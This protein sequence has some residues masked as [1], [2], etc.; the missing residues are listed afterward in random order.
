MGENDETRRYLRIGDLTLDTDTRELRRGDT[1]LDMTGLSYQLLL[2]LAE[3]APAVVSHEEIAER[4]WSGRVVSPET[5]TQRIKLLRQTLGDDARDPRYIALVRGHGYRLLA[6]VEPVD[7]AG[8]ADTPASEQRRVRRPWSVMLAL[9]VVAATVTAVAYIPQLRSTDQSPEPEAADRIPLEKSIAVLP[10]ED[11]SAGSELAYLGDGIADEVMHRL[12]QSDELHVVARTSSFALRDE[13]LD[14][15]AIAAR[16]GVHYVLQGS[17]RKSGDTLRVTAQLVDARRNAQLWSEAYERAADD[18]LGVQRDIAAALGELLEVELG[19]SDR[20]DPPPAAY[21]RLLQGRFYYNRRA[22]GDMK[23]AE[24]AYLEALD[25]AP[26]LAS[27]W[28][29]LAAVY[30]I[31]IWAQAELDKRTGLRKQRAALERALALDPDLASAHARLARVYRIEG[32][33]ETAEYHYRRAWELGSNDPMVLVLRAG[34]TGFQGRLEQ[35]IE[36]QRRAISL[37]PLAAS[38]HHNLGFQL[39]TAGRPEAAEAAF[40]QA[41]SLSGRAREQYAYQFAVARILRS[42]YEKAVTL[43]PQMESAADRIAVRA[44]AAHGLGRTGDA[45]QLTAELASLRGPH[46]VLRLAEV[47]AFRG[48]PGSVFDALDQLESM[49]AG[50][51]NAVPEV[52]RSLWELHASPFIGE[53][54][55]D[56]EL[57]E[58]YT[59]IFEGYYSVD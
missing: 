1:V 49:I 52:D 6:N 22:E 44:M 16:L 26:D 17:L 39:L 9:G 59:G 55:A 46:A 43:V 29:G 23:R 14:I 47:R 54:R 41:I 36:L 24:A 57:L 35:A 10:F 50:Q 7:G 48:D 27:A 13:G 45:D 19:T 3:R 8:T 30:N 31:Q 15:T 18:A 11:M 53:L 42:E 2:L 25:I 28:T 5:V 12:G 20:P 33:S 4:V 58:R 32:E 37:D 21:E 56:R 34:W 38:Y 40:E 51:D